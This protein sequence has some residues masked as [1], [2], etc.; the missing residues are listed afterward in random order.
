MLSLV[1]LSHIAMLA[2]VSNNVCLRKRFWSQQHTSSY[3]AAAGQALLR[4]SGL[5]LSVCTA[6]YCWHVRILQH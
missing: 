2:V 4:L 6:K 1:S 3:L 5:P